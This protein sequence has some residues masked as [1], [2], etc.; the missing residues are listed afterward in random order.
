MKKFSIGSYT[1]NKFDFR[2]A[3]AN[4]TGS[5]NPSETS[6]PGETSLN[7]SWS[8]ASFP[9]LE[10]FERK[11]THYSFAPIVYNVEDIP[12][13]AFTRKDEEGEGKKRSAFKKKTPLCQS[14]W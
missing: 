5:S 2:E 14:D 4:K 10:L 11:T 13:E 8:Q 1:I 6:E 12:A 7:A 9:N 3:K